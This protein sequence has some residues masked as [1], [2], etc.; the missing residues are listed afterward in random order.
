MLDSLL[1]ANLTSTS[2]SSP[3]PSRSAFAIG[4][5]VTLVTVLA[6]VLDS[7]WLRRD[8][9]YTS[10]L[11][12]LS[13]K[14]GASHF[15][16]HRVLGMS[17]LASYL[18]RIYLRFATGFDDPFDHRPGSWA[19]LGTV[20]LHLALSGTSLLFHIPARRNKSSPMIWPE[21]RLH[22]ILFAYRS[23]LAMGLSWACAYLEVPYTSWTAVAGRVALVFANMVLADAVTNH[24]KRIALVAGD[25]ST[26]R[27]M[28]Y[29]VEWSQSKQDLF[30]TYYGLMQFMA[31]AAVMLNPKPYTL[32]M[33]AFP[34]QIAAFLMTCVRKGIMTAT[35]WHYY[36]LLSLVLAL[37]TT[38]DNVQELVETW[39]FGSAL[40]AVRRQLRWSKFTIWGLVSLAAPFVPIAKYP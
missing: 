22:S 2:S 21:F 31:T 12:K 17:A 33:S 36:Y 32:L 20:V 15:H 1:S 25:D 13:T 24:Y 6:G 26:M 27:G 30:T 29:P 4:S 19:V 39:L 3:S 38:V 8:Y 16:V 9:L 5:L 23:F 34:I 28:P 40:Y 7:T 11:Y 10:N 14:E 37:F 18:Y 35:G